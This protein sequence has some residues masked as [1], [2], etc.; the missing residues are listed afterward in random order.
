MLPTTPP[1]RA[2]RVSGVSPGSE[3]ESESCSESIEAGIIP[4]A[5]PEL[6]PTGTSRNEVAS[7]VTEESRVDVELVLLVRVEVKVAVLALKAVLV[8][9]EKYTAVLF[10]KSDG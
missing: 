2:L 7:G 3:W 6:P 10:L 4:S 5:A 9:L 8:W 1:T